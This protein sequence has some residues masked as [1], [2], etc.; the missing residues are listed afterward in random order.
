MWGLDWNLKSALT[1][2]AD[3]HYSTMPS[4]FSSF[5][6]Y[7]LLVT[8]VN[9]K[10]SIPWIFVIEEFFWY[11]QPAMNQLS[12][13]WASKKQK[14]LPISCLIWCKIKPF[15]VYN[16]FLIIYLCTQKMTTIFK[17]FWNYISYIFYMSHLTF[18]SG[19]LFWLYCHVRILILNF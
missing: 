6:I 19:V 3:N 14:S 4:W 9:A 1:I 17:E 16:F 13:M 8:I 5:L 7:Q 10:R 15:H 2:Q 12:N 11:L 18:L